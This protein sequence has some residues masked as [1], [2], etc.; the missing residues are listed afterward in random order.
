[1]SFGLV[2]GLTS[3]AVKGEKAGALSV[4]RAAAIWIEVDVSGEPID[5]DSWRREDGG[6]CDGD[7]PSAEGEEL[8]RD[9]G[10]EA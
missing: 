9:D 5:D 10:E 4:R 6:G 7:V 2:P 3:P 1:M 8:P